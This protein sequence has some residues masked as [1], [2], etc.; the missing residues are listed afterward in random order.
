[1]TVTALLL[2][3]PLA[4]MLIDV[5]RAIRQMNRT[6]SQTH[7]TSVSPPRF[8]TTRPIAVV[9][10]GTILACARITTPAPYEI[11]SDLF[12]T[13]I[14][15]TIFN[16]DGKKRIAGNDFVVLEMSAKEI[17]SSHITLAIRIPRVMA[18]TEIIV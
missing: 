12:Q 17:V 18:V 5:N 16:I 14:L 1:M 13:L 15:R 6:I 9:L 10:P 4:A 3:I 11:H 8:H 7:R 2:A